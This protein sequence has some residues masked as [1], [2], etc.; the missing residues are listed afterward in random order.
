MG[1]SSKSNATNNTTTNTTNKSNSVGVGGDNSGIILSGNEGDI[2]LTQTD[3]GAIQGAF[4]SNNNALDGAFEFGETAINEAFGFGSDA[5]SF[6]VGA[7]DAMNSSTDAA[8]NFAN[9]VNAS[10]STDGA[11]DMMNSKPLVYGAIG[12]VLLL[13][14][15]LLVIGSRK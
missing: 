5:L 11:S 14:V 6:G 4:D 2:Q 13:A 9:S 15:M 3:H 1:G 7:L 12:I 8:L 10:K